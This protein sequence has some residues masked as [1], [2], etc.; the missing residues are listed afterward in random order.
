MLH[1]LD[2]Q[3]NRSVKVIVHLQEF[4]W[5]EKKS[6][7]TVAL[8]SKENFAFCRLFKHCYSSNQPDCP[9]PG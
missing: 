1:I 5:E 4:F 2:L 7:L 3:E 9:P 8:I 6:N